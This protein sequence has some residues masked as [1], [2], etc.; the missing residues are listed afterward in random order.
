MN[1]REKR[2][3][4]PP[5]PQGGLSFLILLEQTRGSPKTTSYDP[6]TDSAERRHTNKRDASLPLPSRAPLF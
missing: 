1:V 6:P 3:S 5:E 4:R 2:L